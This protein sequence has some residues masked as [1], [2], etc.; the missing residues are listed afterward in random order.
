MAAFRAAIIRDATRGKVNEVIDRLRLFALGGDVQAA[1]LYLKYT[2]G[3]PSEAK[4]EVK[5]EE[6]KRFILVPVLNGSS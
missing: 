5:D 2:V 3:Q 4:E 6:G 1:A